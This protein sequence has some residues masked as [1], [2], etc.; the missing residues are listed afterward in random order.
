MKEKMP[1]L[2]AV[3][4]RK[5][6]IVKLYDGL[7]FGVT[8]LLK[9]YDL[10]FPETAAKVAA[11]GFKLGKEGNWNVQ[12]TSR[13]FKVNGQTVK[14]N[15]CISLT[16]GTEIRLAG[17]REEPDADAIFFVFSSSDAYQRTWMQNDFSTAVSYDKRLSG[18]EKGD[19]RWVDGKLNIHLD[20]KLLYQSEDP[21]TSESFLS[22]EVSASVQAQ[23]TTSNDGR[24]Y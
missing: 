16:E 19:C 17:G 7:T 15:Q 23:K 11:G 24:S 9:H 10:E 5:M 20:D 8:S 1:F 6:H 13:S 22:E 4:S 2:Y 18:M 3:I 14:K 12:C 21:A